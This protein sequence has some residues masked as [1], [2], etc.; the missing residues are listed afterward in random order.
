[1]NMLRK[2]QTQVPKQK[3]GGA[4]KL[5]NKEGEDRNSHAEQEH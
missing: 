4:V 1:M 5:R 3:G 2:N